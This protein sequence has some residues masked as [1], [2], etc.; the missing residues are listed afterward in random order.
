MLKILA[1]MWSN[2]KDVL[3]KAFET[4]KGRNDCD[5][6]DIVKIAFGNIF[7]A[8]CAEYGVDK[9][10][11]DNITKIDDGDY[12]GTLLFL[13]P[14]DVYQPCEWEYLMTY[15][16]YGSCS[17]CDVLQSIQD[18]GGGLLSAEQVDDFMALALNIL[19][20]TIKP[21]KR[22]WRDDEKFKEVDE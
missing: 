15:I 7:N 20:N 21:Y 2:N 8:N 6:K 14:F 4:K 18:F 11:L 19:Q 5:Y 13:I 10:D 1:E 12:Q 9:L 22:G 3:R 17:V 16:G